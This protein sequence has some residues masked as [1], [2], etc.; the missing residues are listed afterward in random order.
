MGIKVNLERCQ[1]DGA[2]QEICPCDLMAVDPKTKKAY[3]R[4]NRDCWDCMAC[5]KACPFGALETVL[6]FEAADFGA[7]LTPKVLSE[8]IVWTLKDPDGKEEIFDIK[9]KEI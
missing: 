5:I 7:S 1:G 2:C 6:P 9:T 3:N 4:D 8:R